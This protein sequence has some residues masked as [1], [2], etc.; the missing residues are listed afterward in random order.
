MEGPRPSSTP[1]VAVSLPRPAARPISDYGLIGDTR[2]AALVSS[3]GGIDWLCVPRFDGDP[4]FGKL[5][6]GPAAG[7]FRVAPAERAVVVERRYRRDTATLQTTWA[8]GD[9]R[10]TLA[11]AMVG[12]VTGRLLPSTLLVRRVSA[13]NAPVTV[14]VHFDP[15]L[16]EVHRA[17]RTTRRGQHL[18]C[19]WGALA[20]S[21]S[22]AP[23]LRV[24]P[25]QQ[26]STLVE[27]DNPLTL[28]LALAHREP[29]V[30]I[31][32]AAAWELVAEDEA[33][34]RAWSAEFD[35]GLPFRDTVVRSL[36][37]LRLLTY[38][39]S[40][41][42][43]AAPTTSL[44]EDPG[45]VRNWD[46]RYAWP[47]DASI[48]I[49]AFLQSGKLDEARRFMAWLLHASRLQRPRL[50]VLL[51][52]DGRH[53][54]RERELAGWA[55][56][57]GSVPVRVG[58]GAAD[59]HQL[60]G[61]GW[62]LDAAWVLEEAGQRLY[63]ETWRAMRAFANRV[64]RRWNEPDAGIWEIRGDSAQH[65]H[66]K[67]MAWLALDR[68]L[69][70]ARTHP[71]PGRQ[72]QRW[73][74]ARAA[75]EAEVKERGVDPVRHNYTRTYGS[76]DLDAALLVLPLVGIEGAD[77]N[78]VRATIDAI[79]DELSAGGPLLYRYPPGSDGLP[80]SEGAFLP[81]SFWLVQALAVSGRAAEA[82]QLFEE[83][84]THAT[85][86]GLYAEEMDPR[87]GVHLGNFPQALTHAALVQAAL[88]LRPH[89]TAGPGQ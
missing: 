69:R 12:D 36:L 18:I 83:L 71:L 33:R 82:L 84:L 42:P 7:S 30:D 14:V 10:L 50:P 44:P 15:R 24:E 13:E 61:Y 67:L 89:L 43:V 59:Q 80:G 62:V 68:A 76:Q 53:A 65:V 23:A 60:D 34:W 63:S 79:R 38:S 17:P 27:P 73:E 9:G 11:D 1:P 39:P 26:V 55:G 28:V 51:T 6:G 25:G 74:G 66:S 56:F 46:Y 3:D 64:A 88:S 31:A 70:I 20:L 22:T 29:L 32:P 54:P 87:T 52:L 35:D 78:R 8:V 16:G 21:L 2:T 40:G 75:I 72:R 86:L 45:G 37:T 4:V 58:N 57:A 19:Q 77:G 41:A 48:G 5:I 85:P 47:R 49:A 81:C